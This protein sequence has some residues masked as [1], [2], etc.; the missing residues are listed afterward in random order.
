MD[1]LMVGINATKASMS[2][3]MVASRL[4][5]EGSWKNMTSPMAPRICMGAKMVRMDVPGY[6]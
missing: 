6:L 1:A 2:V 5:R 3:E 4:L